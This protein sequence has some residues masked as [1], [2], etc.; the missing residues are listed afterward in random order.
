MLAADLKPGF[1]CPVCGSTDHPHPFAGAVD[2]VDISPENPQTMAQDVENFRVKQEQAANESHAAKTEYE[3]RKETFVEAVGRLRN[4]MQKSISEIQKDAGL[5]EMNEALKIWKNSIDISL[6]TLKKDAEKLRKIRELLQGADEQRKILKENLELCRATQT[7]AARKLTE[8]TAQLNSFRT[9]C[10][11]ASEKEASDTLEKAETAKQASEKI[12]KK[13]ADALDAASSAKQN[14]ETLIAK[15]QKEIPVQ[16]EKL[17]VKK[18]AYMDFM[19]EKQM[20]EEVWKQLVK[21][22]SRDTEKNLTDTVEAYREAKAAA[23]AQ[24]NAAGETIGDAQKPDLAKIKAEKEAAETAYQ[25]AEKRYSQLKSDYKDNQEILTALSARM[26]KRKAV[27]EEHA[28]IDAL[29]R[30]TSGNVSGSRMDL[31]TFVQRYYLERILYA[32]NR[33]FQEMSAGQF[34]LRMYDL[35]KAGEGKNRGLDLMV[36]STVTG[37]EREV[38]TLSGGES[39]MA[40]LSLALGMA[41]QIKQ[42]SAAINLDMMFIDE[43][44]GSLDEHSRNQAVRVLQEMAEGSRLIGII[45]HVSELKQEIEDQLIV[46]KDENGSHVKWQIS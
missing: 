22:N 27:V 40:A 26:E 2:H 6:K 24:K 25:S 32:A 7:E 1:P 41:D 12:Y 38:R 39:F 35:K 19:Q 9:S 20:T 18:A 21:E 45:S 16:E 11:F 36:Y 13:A 14:A 37:K 4:R 44:F 34:E 31:E 46:T 42:S 23:I 5:S 29:Y 15:Y 8:D 3:T 43:G 30:M 28:R 33:R 10:E 17:A